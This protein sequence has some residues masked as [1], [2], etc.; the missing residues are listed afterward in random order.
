MH[1]LKK[2]SRQP[3]PTEVYPITPGSLT[4]LFA[5]VKTD[6]LLLHQPD[7][8]ILEASPS[9]YPLLG[10]RPEEMAGKLW[11]DFYFIPGA[12]FYNWSGKQ[13]A[14]KAATGEVCRYEVRNKNGMSR[15]VETSCS[16]VA[17]ET[18]L[19]ITRVVQDAM[20]IQHN[21]LN[22]LGSLCNDLYKTQQTIDAELNQ[23][24]WSIVKRSFF[25][26]RVQTLRQFMFLQEAVTKLNTLPY[27]LDEL[28]LGSID[29]PETF[30]RVTDL[31]CV[32]NQVANNYL[33]NIEQA[34]YVDI[35]ED[36]KWP[37]VA[38][39]PLT[40]VAGLE[41]VLYYFYRPADT[42]FGVTTCDFKGDTLHYEVRCHKVTAAQLLQFPE[43]QELPEVEAIQNFLRLYNGSWT[44]KKLPFGGRCMQLKM[45]FKL[46]P[47]ANELQANANS[48]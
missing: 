39:D 47:P 42:L 21:L 37:L 36:S 38:A 29:H 5:S 45:T 8:R 32:F 26:D 24:Q 12:D 10:Y 7:G 1:N 18:Y 44:L 46:I 33:H 14:Q 30:R 20:L 28:N 25:K 41:L 22:S 3:D 40:L 16:E 23:M 9:C 31:G 11:P 17:P 13:L 43:L 34:D 27:I 19:T 6:L 48:R 35:N 15:W 2:H 4:P